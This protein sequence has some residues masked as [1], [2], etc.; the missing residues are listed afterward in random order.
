M[1]DPLKKVR[2]SPMVDKPFEPKEE[3]T[4]LKFDPNIRH[5]PMEMP[6]HLIYRYMY[7]MIP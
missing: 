5:R 1:V 7:G 4:R 3:H 2:D 6:N